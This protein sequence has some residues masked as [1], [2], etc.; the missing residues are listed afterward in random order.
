MGDHHEL[1]TCRRCLKPL[2]TAHVTQ[3]VS[4]VEQRERF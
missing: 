3:L 2:A 4:A 1:P